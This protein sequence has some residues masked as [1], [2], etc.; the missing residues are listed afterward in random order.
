MFSKIQIQ[1]QI[2]Y[3]P[4]KGTPRCVPSDKFTGTG[5]TV[6]Q[7]PGA[8]NTNLLHSAKTLQITIRHAADLRLHL[9]KIVQ[10]K[11]YGETEISAP[12]G[13]LVLDR[14]VVLLFASVSYR[15]FCYTPLFM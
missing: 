15:D 2:G 6:G 13:V 4:K 14:S 9:Q 8:N 1:I 11:L 3:T 10:S 12:T 5:P 7:A